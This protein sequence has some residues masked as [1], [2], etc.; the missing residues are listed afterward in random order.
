MT[1]GPTRR[2]A[3][4]AAAA[5]MVRP[6]ATAAAPALETAIRRLTADAV[7]RH[8]RVQV[9]LPELVENGNAVPITI[10]M[11]SPMQTTDRVTVL[12]LFTE[13]NPAPEVAVFRLGA[14]AAR[15]RVATRIR[16]ATSGRVVALA[17]TAD[18]A[19]WRRDVDVIV[20]LAACVE[21]G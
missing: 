1:A 6:V 12:A 19:W 3:V 11:D 17:R 8:G 13:N 2:E 7:P 10:A 14:G 9:D 5:L 4:L 15:A 20:T 16:L 18:G 21:G